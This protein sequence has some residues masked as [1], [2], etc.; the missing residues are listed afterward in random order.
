M[1]ELREPGKLAAQAGIAPAPFRVTTGW[2]TVI[3]LSSEMVSAAGLAPAMTRS[4]TEGVATTLRADMALLVGL[5]PTVYPQTT[6][7]FSIQLQKQMVG[8]AGNAPV[9][10]F[11]LC[12]AT[13]D[14]QAGS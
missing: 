10:R 7:C 13:P 3:P 9:R 4:Q 6:G 11:R 14:L 1:I 8:S 12:F 5:A 2:T